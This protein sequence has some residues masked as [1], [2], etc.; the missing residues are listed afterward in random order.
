MPR[1]LSIADTSLTS[2][3]VCMFAAGEY[4]SALTDK[5]VS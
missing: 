2:P 3:G 4:G 1:M 5:S